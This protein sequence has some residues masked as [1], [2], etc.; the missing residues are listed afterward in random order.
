M[1]TL[2]YSTID[3]G[4]GPILVDH[5]RD[6]DYVIH[7]A[8]GMV[9][10]YLTPGGNAIGHAHATLTWAQATPFEFALYFTQRN[11]RTVAWTLARD[12]LRSGGGEGDIHVQ[13]L[14]ELMMVE[15]S[16]PSGRIVFALDAIWV[17]RLLDATD[18]I[19]PADEEWNN[20]GGIP[21]NGSLW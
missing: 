10:L 5:S 15:L 11:G 4:P 12:L 9:P 6:D 3:E 16:S 20:V 13:Q 19:V 2:V 18:D 21:D 14:G 1:T 7:G 8:Y 17:D